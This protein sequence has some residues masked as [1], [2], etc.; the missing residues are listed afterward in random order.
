M[1]APGSRSNFPPNIAAQSG[2]FCPPNIPT[3]GALVEKQLDGSFQRQV[4]W[5][6]KPYPQQFPG[7][8][9]SAIAAITS[10]TTKSRIGRAALFFIR[11]LDSSVIYHAE[12]TDLSNKT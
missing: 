11:H 2:R 9:P 10:S 8:C 4:T 5:T 12:R 7:C 6:I 3:L 1:R